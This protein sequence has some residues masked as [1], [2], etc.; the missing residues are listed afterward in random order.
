MENQEPPKK[1]TPEEIEQADGKV[2]QPIQKDSSV[3]L[4]DINKEIENKNQINKDT[5]NK[6]DDIRN[7]LGLPPSDETPPSIK[8][9]L[10]AIDKLN[11]EKS[12]L[13]NQNK[14]SE[15]NQESQVEI[16]KE[17]IDKIINQ[18]NMRYKSEEAFERARKIDTDF[19]PTEIEKVF[20]KYKSQ[21]KNIDYLGHDSN[22]YVGDWLDEGAGGFYRKQPP[23]VSRKKDF[24]EVTNKANPDQITQILQHEY[25]HMFT[26]GHSNFSKKYQ[27]YIKSIFFDEEELKVLS[28]SKDNEILKKEPYP[29]AGPVYKYLTTTGEINAYLGTNLRNDLLRN[30][31]VKNFYDK[32]DKNVLEQALTIKDSN[33]NREKTPIYKIYLTMTKDKEKLVNWLNNYA[34]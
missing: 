13:E 5:K 11:Q 22:I 4:S 7:Q 2:E 34:I 27:E 1:L 12:K 31:L 21:E 26:Q 29:G 14:T 9:E 18:E 32:V 20:N 30:G 3:V 16:K 33:C 25:N 6:I 8:T 10:E 23:L 24:I 15:V 19:P 17:F 28:Q